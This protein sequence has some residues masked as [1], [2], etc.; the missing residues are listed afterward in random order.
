MKGVEASEIHTVDVPGKYDASKI[1]SDV[2]LET[3]VHVAPP[4]FVTHSSVLKNPIKPC[5]VSPKEMTALPTLGVFPAL[6]VIPPFVVLH[7]SVVFEPN[8]PCKRSAQ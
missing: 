6:Q 5:I 7:T 4:S 1:G 8:H 3:A 2:G